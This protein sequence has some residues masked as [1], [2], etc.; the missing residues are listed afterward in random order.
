MWVFSRKL[1]PAPA[2]ILR[3]GATRLT[4]MPSLLVFTAAETLIVG[5]LPIVA[6]SGWTL[7][8]GLSEPTSWH[9]ADAALFDLETPIR[10]AHR[11]IREVSA[12]APFMPLV[13]VG[14]DVMVAQELGESVIHDLRRDLFEKLLSMPMSFFNRAI[15]SSSPSAS[16]SLRSVI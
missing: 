8:T 16:N 5:L 14:D 1:K 13:F 7:R 6:P 10:D 3:M 15:L 9:G 4:V 2:V 12:S 11:H